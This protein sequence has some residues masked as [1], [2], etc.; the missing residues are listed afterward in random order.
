[1]GVG[2]HYATIPPSQ[3]SRIRLFFQ[4]GGNVSVLTSLTPQVDRIICFF[5]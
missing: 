2:F 1:M 4:G 3:A 5:I